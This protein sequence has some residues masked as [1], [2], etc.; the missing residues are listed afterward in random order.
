[1]LKDDY[2]IYEEKMQK[3]IESVERDFDSVRAGRA[4]PSVLNRVMVDY[5]G[6]PTPI[7][8][9]ASI[10]SP[11]PRSLVIQP[12]DASAVKLIKKGH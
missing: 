11:D 10:S 6:T 8:Q 4:N 7:A 2:K 9:I 3:S 5:Y 12:W 1:M